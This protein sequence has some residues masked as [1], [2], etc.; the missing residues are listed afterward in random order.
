[1][2]RLSYSIRP[3]PFNSP[4][5]RTLVEELNQEINPLYEGFE[6]D[7]LHVPEN[8]NAEST[9]EAPADSDEVNVLFLV[10]FT[11]SAPDLGSRGSETQQLQIS[12][13][14]D[15]SPADASA[16]GCVAIKIYAR[17]P[18]NALAPL[19]Q[20]TPKV[21]EVKRLYVREKARGHGLADALLRAIEHEAGARLGID[22]LVLETGFRQV[23]AMKVYE[24][25]GW[26]RRGCFGN[27]VGYEGN[28]GV[29]GAVSVCFEKW[30]GPLEG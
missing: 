6:P 19:A 26:R 4:L 3:H 20:G 9:L 8:A 12:S 1:M 13:P 23:P 10:A 24:R 27:Y 14:T 17:P 18:A 16:L 2:S 7:G 25:Q 5:T 22:L 30:V 21:G 15:I 28:E 29:E 11:N